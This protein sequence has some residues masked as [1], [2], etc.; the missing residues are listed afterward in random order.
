[1]QIEKTF[2]RV[3]SRVVNSDVLQI[4]PRLL[5]HHKKITGVLGFY[6]QKTFVNSREFYIEAS[7]GY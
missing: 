5:E 1:M 6:F 7:F 4:M 3:S 2:S